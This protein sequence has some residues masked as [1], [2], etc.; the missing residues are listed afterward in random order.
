MLDLKDVANNLASDHADKLE[1]AI[2]LELQKKNLIF[3][4]DNK[5]KLTQKFNVR[6]KEIREVKQE[7]FSKLVDKVSNLE[8]HLPDGF[9]DSDKNDWDVVDDLIHELKEELFDIKP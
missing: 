8:K 6:L 9:E 5:V 2:V 7:I 3:V 4:E 1:E